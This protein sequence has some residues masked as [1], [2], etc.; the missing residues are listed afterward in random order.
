MY[1]YLQERTESV[2]VAS[3][4]RCMDQCPHREGTGSMYGSGNAAGTDLA[5]V[6]WLKS[7]RNSEI[8]HSSSVVIPVA[9]KTDTDV[10]PTGAPA[11]VVDGASGCQR[12]VLNCFRPGIYD[13]FLVK[14][15]MLGLAGNSSCK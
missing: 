1:M 8:G 6:L 13:N 15:Q 9:R 12:V 4:F 14:K 2:E 3:L 5:S 7:W 11:L 10:N